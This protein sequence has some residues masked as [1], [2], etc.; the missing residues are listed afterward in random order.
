VVAVAVLDAGCLL[1]L[2]PGRPPLSAVLRTRLALKSDL[3]LAL[4]VNIMNLT[5][6]TI[7]LEIDQARRLVYVHVLDVGLAAVGG[8]VL[9]AGDKLE[10]AAGGGVRAGSR[11]AARSKRIRGRTMTI[12]T[13]DRG[14]IAEK[15]AR[16]RQQTPH[17]RGDDM[18]IVVG[19]G[20]GDADR[21]GRR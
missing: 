20:R 4:G 14:V 6:G 10:S 11:M 7:V 1:A 13:A 8:P 19:P 17:S 15:T 18:T 9:P 2:R 12:G 3:V 16:T 21:G 5:P